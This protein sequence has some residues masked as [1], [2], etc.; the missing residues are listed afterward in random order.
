MKQLRS[1]RSDLSHGI[2]RAPAWA[3]FVAAVIVGCGRGPGAT[4]EGQVTID[5]KPIEN[6]WIRFA[7]AKGD[8]RTTGSVIQQGRYWAAVTQGPVRVSVQGYVKVGEERPH[9]DQS[10]P[11]LPIMKPLL[12]QED[13][14]PVG[15]K[16]IESGRNTL[17]FAL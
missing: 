16:T 5:G 3:A 4:V 9:G 13:L 1:M 6:G 7:P 2:C 10:A 11:L 17:D 14:G 8:G 12:T 15:E